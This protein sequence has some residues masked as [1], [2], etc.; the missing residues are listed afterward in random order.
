MQ[1]ASVS[2][3]VGH[4]IRLK[5]FGDFCHQQRL[6]YIFEPEL[7]PA[8]RLTAFNPICLNIFSSGKCTILGLRHLSFQ[9]YIRRVIY[10]IN[11][12]ECEEVGDLKNIN[13][14]NE[15]SNPVRIR[16]DGAA[17]IQCVKG[18]TQGIS[19][20]EGRN[21]IIIDGDGSNNQS[22]TSGR[23]TKRK[24]SKT[25]KTSAAR[26]SHHHKKEEVGGKAAAAAV[27]KKAKH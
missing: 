16:E 20:T 3:N 24:R 12:S 8:L 7:F 9:K 23:S 13:S 6:P 18:E 2:F 22:S 21:I 5:K 14:D 4:R 19:K 27:N 1:S 26:K 10:F 11:R 17:T 15:K 25:S